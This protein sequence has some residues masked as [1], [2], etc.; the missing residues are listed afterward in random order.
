MAYCT[1]ADVKTY[2]GVSGAGDDTLIGTLIDAAQAAIDTYTS[3]T[4]E[5]A[6]DSTR[7]FDAAGEHITRGHLYVDGDLCQIT[8]VT[9][10]DSVVV[11][12]D[13]YTTMPRNVTPF[14]GLR[15]LSNSNIIWTYTDEYI[16]AITIVGRW[17][18]S[19]TAPDDIAQ[20]CIRLASF[21]YRQ[22][23]AQLADVTAIEAGVVVSTPAMPAEVQMTLAK[24][25]RFS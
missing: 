3:R 12:S 8:T 5:A 2:L 13:E 14:F 7:Y 15:L 10:G 23:D 6:A 21:Y 19:V 11:A 1:A 24:Y 4:F 25:R 22:K 18:F 17:A 16:N 9:N 20:A